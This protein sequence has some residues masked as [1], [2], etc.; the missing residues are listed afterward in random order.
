MS[1]PEHPPSRQEVCRTPSRRRPAAKHMSTARQPR[2]RDACPARQ[3]L[4]DPDHEAFV[5]WF[6]TYWRHH[7][8]QLFAGDTTSREA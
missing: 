7:G 2:S 6:V 4:L 3:R 5:D 1:D 8:T